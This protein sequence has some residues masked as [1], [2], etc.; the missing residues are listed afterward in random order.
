MER[1]FDEER[2]ESAGQL[3][4]SAKGLQ[5]RQSVRATFRLPE[6]IIQLLGVMARQLGLQQKSLFDQLI[7]DS[8]VLRQVASTRHSFNPSPGRRRQKTYVLSKRSLQILDRVARREDIPR[9]VL[10]EISIQ[11]LLPVLSVEQKKHRKR[12]ELQEKFDTLRRQFMRLAAEA[13]QELGEDDQAVLFLQEV[14]DVLEDSFSG[15]NAVVEKG[16][17]IEQLLKKDNPVQ[18]LLDNSNAFG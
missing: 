18:Q 9:D 11:R 7:E 1:V 5:G 6:E 13:D 14:C 4:I 2:K 12:A 10:V 15:L 16:Q 17:A 3:F 8:D